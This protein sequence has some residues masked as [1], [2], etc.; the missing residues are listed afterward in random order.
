MQD[1][2]TTLKFES[3][4]SIF[5]VGPSGSGKTALATKKKKIKIENVKRL[6]S[7]PPSSVFFCY[8]ILQESYTKMQQSIPNIV[9]YKGPPNMDQL[10]E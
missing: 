4:T 2:H 10:N 6:F 1:S 7:T 9:F 5:F 3:P 8:S